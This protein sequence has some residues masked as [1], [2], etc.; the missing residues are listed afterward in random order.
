MDFTKPQRRWFWATLTLSSISIVALVFALW[1]LVEYR[2][3]RDVDYLSLH[4]LYVSRGIVSSLLLAFWAAWFVL[5]ERQTAEKQLRRSHERYRKLLEVDPSAMALC[6]STLNV[7]E[8]NGAAERLYGYS[9]A[10]AIG[11]RLHTVPAGKDDELSGL[12][13]RVEAGDVVLDLETLR[14]D[15]HGTNI[16]V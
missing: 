9:K 5:R 8:W 3:F 12:L 11:A 1:E 13:R 7:L 10:D 14:C 2:F 6:D 4:Y 15:R 16:E